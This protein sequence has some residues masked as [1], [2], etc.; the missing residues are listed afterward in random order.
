[1]DRLVEV[2]EG[3]VQ[4]EVL[5][6]KT[7]VANREVK[8]LTRKAVVE[9]AMKAVMDGGVRRMIKGKM[10]ISPRQTKRNKATNQASHQHQQKGVG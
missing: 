9:K 10:R 8:A 6:A 4:E 1:M 7:R 2:V 5:E 3:R